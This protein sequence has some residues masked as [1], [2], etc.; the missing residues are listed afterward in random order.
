MEHENSKLHAI[1][2]NT[3]VFRIAYIIDLFFCSIGYLNVAA[4]VGKV[5]FFVWGLSIFFNK[6]IYDFSI[7]KINYYGWLLLFIASNIV[8]VL[9]RGYDDGIWESI[10]MVLNMPIMFFLFYGLHS[11]ITAKGGRK[12]VLKELYILCNI[13]M[14]LSLAVNIVSILALYLVGKSVSYS[15]GDLVVYENRF[16]GVYFNPNLMAF[17]SFCSA[18]CCHIIWQREFCFEVT[19]R[20]I[21]VFKKIMIIV[22]LALNMFVILLTDSNATALIIVCYLITFI[23]YRYFAGKKLHIRLFFRKGIVLVLAFALI[24]VGVFTVR[25]MFQTGTTH[26]MN[27]RGGETVNA[28]D[29]SD[30]ELNQITFEHQNK[31][32]DSG[33]IKLFKQGVNVVKHHPIFGVGKGNITKYGNRYNDNKMKYSDFHNG[34]LTIIVCSGFTGFILFLGFAICLGWRMANVL[35]KIRPVIK[36]NIFPC[37]V[38]F[39]TAYCVYSFFEKTLVFEVSFMITFFWLILGYATAC[40]AMYEGEKYAEYPFSSLVLLKRLKKGQTSEPEEVHQQD[41]S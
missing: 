32:L 28:F 2:N 18:V 10:L 23:C 27:N 3:S 9:I 13:F 34:Y 17:S 33:R 40:M 35:F 24:T 15:F 19:K 7:K 4:E 11:E 12:K 36:H 25:Y 37:L 14:W 38:A 16:T 6:Y 1:Y 31:N 22:S 8:T 39:V 41:L 21:S 29:D 30:D 20:E 26:T 5:F